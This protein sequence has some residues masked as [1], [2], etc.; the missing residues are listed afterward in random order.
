[1]KAKDFNGPFNHLAETVM[2]TLRELVRHPNAQAL[3]SSDLTEKQRQK[4]HDLLEPVADAAANALS[5]RYGK[6]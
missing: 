6:K 5:M 2:E 1:M 4:L 3:A